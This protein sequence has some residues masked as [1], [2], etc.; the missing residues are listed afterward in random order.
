MSSEYFA[1]V[2][3]W[4]LIDVDGEPHSL[5][6]DADLVGRDV[7]FA[8]LGRDVKDAGLRHDQE[9]AVGVVQAWS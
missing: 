1:N 8:E 7:Q 4:R 5:L 6:N 2:T 9:V 3:S